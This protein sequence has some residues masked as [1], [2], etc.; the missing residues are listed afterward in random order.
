M[1]RKFLGLLYK[2]SVNRVFLFKMYSNGDCFIHLI[3]QYYTYTLFS[4]ISFHC[5]TFFQLILSYAILL[6]DVQ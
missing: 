6:T 4:K 3:A 2:L 5:L 1:S